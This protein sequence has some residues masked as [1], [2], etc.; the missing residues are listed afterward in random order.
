MLA[1]QE[2]NS[3]LVR[4]ADMTKR[5]DAPGRYSPGSPRGLAN[6]R[7]IYAATWLVMLHQAGAAKVYPVERARYQRRSCLAVVARTFALTRIQD[8]QQVGIG[9]DPGT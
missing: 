9:S 7:D 8:S 1:P 2:H 3:D 5:L 6:S 4:Q